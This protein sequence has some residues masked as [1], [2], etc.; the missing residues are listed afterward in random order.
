MN[1][2]TKQK[3]NHR[4]RRNLWGLAESVGRRVV[5]EF[6]TDKYTLECCA[7]AGIKTIPKKKKCKKGKMVI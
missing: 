5:R 7:K 1:L 6:E 4:Q 3:Q 2:F